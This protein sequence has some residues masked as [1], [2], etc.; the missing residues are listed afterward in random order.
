MFLCIPQNSLECSQQEPQLSTSVT[1]SL[2]KEHMPPLFYSSQPHTPIFFLVITFQ[3]NLPSGKLHW[4]MKCSAAALLWDQRP[5]S[6]RSWKYCLL[7]ALWEL[8][9]NERAALL[10]AIQ[11]FYGELTSK[12]RSVLQYKG[13]DLFPSWEQLCKAISDS[14]PSVELA[15]ASVGKTSPFN[16]PICQIQ[17]YFLIHVDLENPLSTNLY[18]RPCFQVPK[19][20]SPCPRICLGDVTQAK[21][22]AMN[23][24]SL[25]FLSPHPECMWVC[26]GGLG[27]HL[28]FKDI[29]W[30]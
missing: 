4:L 26:F 20:T 24:F 5:S 29:L 30:F 10:K 2:N 22:G 19:D 23:S 25:P 7:M 9:F 21:A 28:L 15:E 16:F 1:S 6:Q 3:N 11:L 13:L 14:E 27:D 17:F 18:L 12:D 8:L